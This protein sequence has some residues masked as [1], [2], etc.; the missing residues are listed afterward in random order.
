MRPALVLL[1]AV[2]LKM[3]PSGDGGAAADM[4]FVAVPVY[5]L[6]WKRFEDRASISSASKSID[7]VLRTFVLRGEVTAPGLGRVWVRP[8]ALGEGVSRLSLSGTMI[9]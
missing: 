9:N 6:T 3:S 7:L 2:P 8:L 1:D 4:A 5:G